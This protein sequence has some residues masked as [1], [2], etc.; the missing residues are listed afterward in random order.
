MTCAEVA[1]DL[2]SLIDA[3]NAPIFGINVDGQA[4]TSGHMLSFMAREEELGRAE[5]TRA[6]TCTSVRRLFPFQTLLLVPLVGQVRRLVVP[7][8]SD[9]YR[10]GWGPKVSEW[11]RKVAAL[12][13]FDKQEVPLHLP[14]LQCFDDFDVLVM[15][16]FKP[17]QAITNMID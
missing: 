2:S 9:S 1:D 4:N 17:S 14:A 10:P 7:I 8:P 12:T 6:G 11:N 3:A 13:G 16:A 5:I 15:A